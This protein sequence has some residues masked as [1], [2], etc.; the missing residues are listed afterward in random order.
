MRTFHIHLQYG[1]V[2]RSLSIQAES[3]SDAYKKVESLVKPQWVITDV[4]DQG[5]EFKNGQPYWTIEGDG[6]EAELVEHTFSD[7]IGL[8]GLAEKD[9]YE[10]R[11]YLTHRSAWLALERIKNTP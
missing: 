11:Y 9:G 3:T 6:P 7:E 8:D 10:Q 4:I 1:I 2:T 5:N